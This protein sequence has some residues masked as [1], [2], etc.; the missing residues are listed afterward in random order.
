MQP[1]A[2]PLDTPVP[3]KLDRLG[4]SLRD[5]IAM[6]H[7]LKSSAWISA[8]TIATSSGSSCAKARGQA[9]GPWLLGLLVLGVSRSGTLLHAALRALRTERCGWHLLHRRVPFFPTVALLASL[10]SVA[11]SHA[12]RSL[13]WRSSTNDGY[14][15]PEEEMIAA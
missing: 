10:P 13:C 9:R 4:R 12:R 15:K 5:L 1:F 8:R 2:G 7:D 3:W 14:C 11:A 6:L